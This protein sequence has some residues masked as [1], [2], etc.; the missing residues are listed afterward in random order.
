MKKKWGFGVLFLLL[1]I[2][3]SAIWLVHT[4]DSLVHRDSTQQSA[5]E[6]TVPFTEPVQ[7]QVHKGDLLLVNHQ[8]PI[9]RESIKTDIVV[10]AKQEDRDQSYVLLDSKLM[11]SRQVLEQFQQMIAA[12]AE[13]GVHSFIMSSGYRNWDKQNE[14]YQQKG[15][16]YALPAGHS[17]HNLGLSLDIGST[18][19]TMD[20]APEGQWLASN[21]WKYGFILRYPQDRVDITGIQYEPWHFRYVGLPHSAIMY[22]KNLVLE[23]YLNLLQVKKTIDATVGGNE[24]YIRYYD[25]TSGAP[26]YVPKHDDYDISGDNKQGIIVTVRKEAE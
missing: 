8:Y 22:Q 21:A 18:V 19:N 13:D 11:L 16:D 12:A 6:D 9:G 1:A 15:A 3:I 5:S 20:Q 23:Q 14:L 26:I 7:E 10:V 25:T 4:Q 24:Y 17:E 2:M